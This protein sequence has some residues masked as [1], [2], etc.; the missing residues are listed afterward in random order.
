MVGEGPGDFITMSDGGSTR[1]GWGAGGAAGGVGVDDMAGDGA[2]LFFL[3]ITRRILILPTATGPGLSS[4]PVGLE[5]VGRGIA[6]GADLATMPFDGGGGTLR[7]RTTGF[8]PGGDALAVS[9][10]SRLRFNVG[11]KPL[12]ACVLVAVSLLAMDWGPSTLR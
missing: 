2:G 10:K 5:A 4:G 12:C 7:I 8:T 3:S 1:N 11:V 9:S 6:R